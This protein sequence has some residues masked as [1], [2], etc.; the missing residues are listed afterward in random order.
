MALMQTCIPMQY[1][2]STKAPPG[3]SNAIQLIWVTLVVNAV[4]SALD[5]DDA[6]SEAIA[7]NTILLAFSGFVTIKIAEGK[8]WARIA[9]SAL[10][11]LDIALIF[12][13]GMD[14]ATDL[15]AYVSV[16]LLAIEGWILIRLFN[17]EADQWF[18][19]S[20]KN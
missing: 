5:F 13:F 20:R 1:T 18:K 4:M 8:N 11:A 17:A 10:V 6:S 19:S 3:V 9:Y 7:L 2:S 12:A 14:E 15:E 16:I